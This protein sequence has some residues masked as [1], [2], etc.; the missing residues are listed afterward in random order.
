MVSRKMGIVMMLFLTLMAQL[1]VGQSVPEKPADISPLLIGEK[2][3]DMILKTADGKDKNLLNLLAEKSSVV[4]FYRGG[5]CP[6]CNMHLAELQTVEKEIVDLGYQII[7]ISPDSPE[8]LQ[9]SVDKHKLSYTLMSDSDLKVATAF[10]ISFLTPESQKEKLMKASGGVNPGMLPVPSVF[11]L[12]KKGEI[13]FEYINPDFKKRIPAKLLM[14][15]L[16]ALKD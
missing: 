9:G 7:A 10:G 14:A 16:T 1:V 6:F 8:N 15:T 5:W 2:A 11:V 3:P 12:N 13:L 4:I